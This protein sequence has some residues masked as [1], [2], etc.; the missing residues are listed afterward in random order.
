MKIVS[1]IG[2]KASMT[3]GGVT[4]RNGKKYRVSD[5]RAET[6]D[7]EVFEIVDD[8]SEEEAPVA[9]ETQT[10]PGAGGKPGQGSGGADNTKNDA[11]TV[12]AK[13]ADKSQRPPK[14]GKETIKTPGVK[15]NFAKGDTSD[16]ADTEEGDTPEGSEGNDPTPAAEGSDKVEE[17]SEVSEIDPNAPTF[18]AKAFATKKE[19]LSYRDEN[20]PEIEFKPTAALKTMNND[21]QAAYQAQTGEGADENSDVQPEQGEGIENID[22]AGAKTV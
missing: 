6:L 4:F 16:D 19:A 1:L 10:K 7:P 22:T 12:E 14:K 21:L 8:V 20:F 17:V 5:D 18:P 9:R 3:T 15:L 11:K 2:T 13:Q